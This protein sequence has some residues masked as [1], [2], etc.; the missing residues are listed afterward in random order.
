MAT[1]VQKLRQVNLKRLVEELFAGNASEAGRKLKTSHT[2]MWQIL[3][4]HRGIGERSAREIEAKL[5]LQPYDLDKRH[6]G[7]ATP[8]VALVKVPL[9]SIAAIKG[10]PVD[11]VLCPIA[12]CSP[13][14]FA[15]TVDADTELMMDEFTE[16]EVVFIDPAAEL[17][18][19]S[20]CLVINRGARARLL[21][22]RADGSGGFE[23][24]STAKKLP[25]TE[26]FTVLGRAIAATRRF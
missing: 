3:S 13:K 18:A 22:A 10:K 16:G 4:G 25:I 1:M 5:K 17:I 23:F 8:A 24:Y 26:A 12:G 9:L 15:V 2:Y 6:G 19:K 7:K 11:H 20:L 14:V 21:Q